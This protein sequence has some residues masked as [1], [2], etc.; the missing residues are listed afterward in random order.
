MN[1]DLCP[2][3]LE[4]IGLTAIDSAASTILAKRKAWHHYFMTTMSFFRYLFE[5]FIR[6]VDSRLSFWKAW[7]FF[8]PDI[9]QLLGNWRY[10]QAIILFVDSCNHGPPS[11]VLTK[12][13]WLILLFHFIWWLSQFF[14]TLYLFVSFR[15]GVGAHRFLRCNL[16]PLY[17]HNTSIFYLLFRFCFSRN[18]P[19]KVVFQKCCDRMSQINWWNSKGINIRPCF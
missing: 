1:T 16:P 11:Y 7:N 9:C 10:C 2:I 8:I 6:N 17:D 12:F 4:F 14:L 13:H 5:C 3:Q 15:Y 19:C 18:C